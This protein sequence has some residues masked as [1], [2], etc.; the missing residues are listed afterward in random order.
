MHHEGMLTQTCNSKR[1][2]ISFRRS[3]AEL[4]SPTPTLL[5]NG[6]DFLANIVWA[7]MGSL[8]TT[9]PITMKHGMNHE[10]EGLQKHSK[11][12]RAPAAKATIR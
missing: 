11:R 7:P 6:H 10:L 8:A 4:P 9:A 5:S 1:C 2:L 12:K 3:S